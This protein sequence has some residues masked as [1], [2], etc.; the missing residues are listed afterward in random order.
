[1]AGQKCKILHKHS[2]YSKISVPHSKAIARI[3]KLFIILLGKRSES[4]FFGWR[5]LNYFYDWK[6][7]FLKLTNE[8]KINKNS[9]ENYFFSISRQPSHHFHKNVKRIDTQWYLLILSVLNKLS[10]KR[11][12]TWST[13][14][15]CPSLL[16]FQ[17]D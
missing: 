9:F 16:H 10:S 11:P 3:H 5:L 13:W 15:P 14:Y 17:S 2:K 4:I 8:F 1:M 6:H 7:F 12:I